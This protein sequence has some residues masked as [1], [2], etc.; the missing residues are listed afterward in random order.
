MKDTTSKLHSRGDRHREKDNTPNDEEFKVKKSHHRKKPEEIQAKSDNPKL[1][2]VKKYVKESP[3]R[4]SS[5]GRKI[6]TKTKEFPSEKRKPSLDSSSDESKLEEIPNPQVVMGKRKRS[7]VREESSESSSN[8]QVY[9]KHIVSKQRSPSNSSKSK[10]SNEQQQPMARRSTREE[11]KVKTQKN[12][13]NSSI[14]QYKYKPNPPKPIKDVA[15]GNLVTEKG[16]FLYGDKAKKI[17]SAKFINDEI[18]CNIEWLPRKD[19]VTP[20]SSCFTNTIIKEYDP[21]FLANYYETKMIPPQPKKNLRSNKIFYFIKT[22]IC[23]FLF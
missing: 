17:I 11:K 12:N 6:F 3:E 5:K 4:K 16:S 18:I 20:L 1:K 7:P 22:K 13:Q 14:E 23:F 8:N 15:R 19:G 2:T 21:L 10:K 9:K